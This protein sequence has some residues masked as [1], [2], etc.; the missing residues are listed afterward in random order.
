M[1]QTSVTRPSNN[2]RRRK[3]GGLGRHASGRKSKCLR[4]DSLTA[5]FQSRLESSLASNEEQSQST[6]TSPTVN[7]K[8]RLKSIHNK[9]DYANKKTSSESD[10]VQQLQDECNELE[11]KNIDIRHQ[12]KKLKAKLVVT[13]VS[14]E[15]VAH[16]LKDRSK[17]VAIV[18]ANAKKTNNEQKKTSK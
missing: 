11:G 12:N 5:T 13:E 17:R 16:A 10:K 15:K 18:L 2:K 3:K 6:N 7:E 1:D 9:L 14:A 4:S 8:Y